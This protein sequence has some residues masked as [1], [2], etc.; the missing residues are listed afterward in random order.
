[1]VF[2]K[3]KLAMGQMLVEGGRIGE[4]LKR[5]EEMISK[6]SEE[7]CQVIVLPE[8]LDVGW[9]HPT[10]RLLATK[11]PGET[12]D[13]LCRV[14]ERNS[15]MVVAGLTER[16]GDRIHNSALLI[17]QLGRI[18]LRHRKINLLDI[19]QDLYSVG[20]TLSVVETE[21]GMM[22][23]NICADNFRN[24]LAIG[25]VQA[26]MGAH[27]LFSPSAWAVDSDH[28]N[29]KDPYGEEWRRSYH[30]LSRLYGISVVGVSNVGRIEGG[31][32]RGKKVIGCSLA[33]GT[34]GEVLAKGPYGHDAEALITFRLQA[35]P[36]DVR[37]TDYGPYLR[38]K[39]YEGP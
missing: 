13:R 9:A 5:A 18:L 7:K 8:C 11:I 19:E 24:S 6:A 34:E 21:F 22:G 39:G 14:A 15:I 25:H 3:F 30:E 29:T 12:S 33:V 16:E 27:F 4:N 37:G 28:D 36:R 35:R 32:W 23:V 10:A 26:R 20:N 2:T 38:G 17:D 1:M 31:P